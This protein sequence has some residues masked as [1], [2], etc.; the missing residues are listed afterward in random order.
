M[1]LIPIRKP[2]AAAPMISCCLCS[3]TWRA[4]VGH[5]GDLA[6]QRFDVGP[7]LLALGLDVA[8]DLLRRAAGLA[9][10]RGPRRFRI[11]AHLLLPFSISL[12][13]LASSIAWVG[14]G[15]EPAFTAL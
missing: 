12:V 4:P 13:S 1:S 14:I 3:S 5:F 2:T 9:G 10:G 6:A 7:E 8:A 15:G 11:D